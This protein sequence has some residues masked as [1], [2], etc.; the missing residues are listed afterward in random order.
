MKTYKSKTTLPI[1]EAKDIIGYLSESYRD[2]L[3]ARILFNNNQLIQACSLAN[4]TIEKFL[5]ALIST[6]KKKVKWRH[7]LSEL[8]IDI[9]EYDLDLYHSLNTDFLNVLTKIYS[10]RYIGSC[11]TGYNMVI[12]RNKFLAELDYTYSLLEPKIQVQEANQTTKKITR[13]D[14]DISIKEAALL[15]NNYVLL[16]IDKTKFIEQLDFVFELRIHNH[17]IMEVSYSTIESKND[18]KFSF[19]SLVPKGTENRSFQMC[20]KAYEEDNK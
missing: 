5:K 12:L 4:T 16:G 9:K 10:S 11:D 7:N 18:G 15:T 19:D 6:S 20:Y 17:Q 8:L 1:I 13:Y 2:Y 14:R 3:A